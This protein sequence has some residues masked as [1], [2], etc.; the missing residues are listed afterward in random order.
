M[1]GAQSKM[2]C[3]AHWI[4]GSF[5][6]SLIR[7]Q[8]FRVDLEEP[9]SFPLPISDIFSLM[10]SCHSLLLFT[11]FNRYETLQPRS[12][13]AHSHSKWLCLMNDKLER[14]AIPR[15]NGVLIQFKIIPSMKMKHKT[16]DINVVIYYAVILTIRFSGEFKAHSSRMIPTL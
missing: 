14:C 13:Q 9:T 6:S 3:H 8:V 5:R 10:E 16:L 12:I 4:V 2:Y 1:T 15:R 7:S 11:C